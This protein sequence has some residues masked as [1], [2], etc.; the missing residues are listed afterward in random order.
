MKLE[1]QLSAQRQPPVAVAEL[2]VSYMTREDFIAAFMASS[3]G[4]AADAHEKVFRGVREQL[5]GL[6]DKQQFEILFQV[7][8]KRQCGDAPVCDAAVLLRELS[9]ECPISCEEAVR[10]MLP[11]WDVSIEEVPFYLVAHFGAGR[12]R[13]AVREVQHQVSSQ[14]EKASLDTI[15]YWV[16]IYD[17]AYAQKRS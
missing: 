15:V 17:E 2:D 14:P 3:E 10:A 7:A 8:V 4:D 9:P 16:G 1:T 5:R 12:V 6:S 11:S 13:D